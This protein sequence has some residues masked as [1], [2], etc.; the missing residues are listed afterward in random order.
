LTWWCDGDDGARVGAAGEE[1]AER[2]V[3]DESLPHRLVDVGGEP[4]R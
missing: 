3:G 4:L 1:D 2:H